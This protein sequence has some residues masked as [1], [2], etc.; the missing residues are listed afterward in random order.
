MTSKRCIGPFLRKKNMSRNNLMNNNFV[1]LN[2]T[3]THL[4]K[5]VNI[6]KSSPAIIILILVIIGFSCISAYSISLDYNRETN[7]SENQ[8]TTEEIGRMQS[9]SIFIYWS[10]TTSLL[11]PLAFGIIG[12]LLISQENEDDIIKYI[13]TYKTHTIAIYLSKLILLF[14]ITGIIYIAIVI[15]FQLIFFAVNGDIIEITSILTAFLFPITG[16]LIIGMIGLLMASAVKSRYS[17][18]VVTLAF[19]FI[20]YGLSGLAWSEGTNA[21]DHSSGG[22]YEFNIINTILYMINPM[23]IKEGML[24]VLGLHNTEEVF[25][26]DYYQVLDGMTRIIYI[27]IALLLISSINIIILHY[28][29]PVNYDQ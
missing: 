3:L 22:P 28:K 26:Q 9:E 20:T 8:L 17:A 15:L 5:D 18:I 16:L 4:W 12:A 13:F 29:R 2:N 6:L 27:I 25:F 7:D 19:V 23:I 1:I 14:V 21:F 11:W 10:G 24:D